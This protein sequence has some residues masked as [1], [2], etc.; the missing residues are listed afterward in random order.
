MEC[1]TNYPYNNS[2]IDIYKKSEISS[3]I[4]T[5]KIIVEYIENKI[6]KYN[7]TYIANSLNNDLSKY[8][9]RKCNFYYNYIVEFNQLLM[10]SSA[11]DNIQKYYKSLSSLNYYKTLRKNWNS[12]NA[13]KIEKKSIENAKDIL[14]YFC[15]NDIVNYTIFPIS[16]GVAIQLSEEDGVFEV[17]IYNSEVKVFINKMGMSSLSNYSIKSF[18]ANKKIYERLVEFYE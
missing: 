6:T 5:N 3:D 11:N 15:N 10:Y 4:D 12:Y 14:L 18:D 7:Q 9:S 2:Y 8:D 17:E 13:K 16:G 1:I